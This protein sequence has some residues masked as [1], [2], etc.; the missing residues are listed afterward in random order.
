METRPSILAGP[1]EPPL[2]DMTLG[3]LLKQRATE[4]PSNPCIVFPE[5]HHRATYE[6]LYKKTLSAAKGLLSGGVRHGD[7]I[8]ILAGNCSPYV[9]LLFAASHIGAVLVVF[10]CS[11]TSAEL[12]SALVH[13]GSNSSASR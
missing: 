8:G 11:Y 2:W 12:S 1:L 9:E 3:E 6:L 10:N 7:R 4:G 5:V 13:S